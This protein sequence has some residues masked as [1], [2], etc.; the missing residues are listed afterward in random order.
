MQL[1]SIKVKHAAVNGDIIHVANQPFI[2]RKRNEMEQ[3]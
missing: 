3:L 1:R 2:W